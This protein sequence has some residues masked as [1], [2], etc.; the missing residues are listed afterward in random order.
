MKCIGDRLPRVTVDT[1]HFTEFERSPDELTLMKSSPSYVELPQLR[2]DQ[3]RSPR[4]CRIPEDVPRQELG[5]PHRHDASALSDLDALA[6][7][8]AVLRL[9]PA[10]FIDQSRSY[11]L[12]SHFCSKLAE[13]DILGARADYRVADV[14]RR[15]VTLPGPGGM[16]SVLG[17]SLSNQ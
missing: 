7:A 8:S 14:G 4:T 6:V 16:R 9:T 10:C 12:R 15:A 1:I 2:G 13:S 11:H 17:P 3:E 5:V